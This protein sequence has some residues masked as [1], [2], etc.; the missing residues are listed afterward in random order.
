MWPS[1]SLMLRQQAG[2]VLDPFLSLLWLQW[3]SFECRG[4]GWVCME[5]WRAFTDET[6]HPLAV[7]PA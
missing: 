5:G 2:S 3:D 4:W 6:F 1:M 7:Q